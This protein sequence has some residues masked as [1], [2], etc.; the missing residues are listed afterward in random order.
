MATVEHHAILKAE[1]SVVTN[2]LWFWG[3]LGENGKDKLV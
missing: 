2:E 3:D 1:L